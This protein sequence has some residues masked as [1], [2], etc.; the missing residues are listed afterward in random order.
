M[1]GVTNVR[2]C[3]VSEFSLRDRSIEVKSEAR[4]DDI[5]SGW[6]IFHQVGKFVVGSGNTPSGWDVL[7]RVGKY[8]VRSE[9]LGVE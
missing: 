5:L 8:S 9:V 2:S 7:H 1:S 6:K 4:V 3:N